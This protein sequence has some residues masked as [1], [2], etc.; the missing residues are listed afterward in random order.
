MQ[1]IAINWYEENITTVDEA[2]AHSK[3]FRK[4]Y[5]SIM[6]AFGL[7]QNPAPVQE[8]YMKR[9]LEN[10]GF[11]LSLIIE[12]CNRTINA[13]NKPSF[14]YADTILKHWKDNHITNVEQAKAFSQQQKS[15]KTFVNNYQQLHNFEQRDYDFDELEKKLLKKQLGDEYR[16]I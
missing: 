10:D 4:E 5:Y 11:D 12:A 3:N 2:K 8:Q 15:P 9:W 16:E 1:T 7:N 14:P 13:I 6:R